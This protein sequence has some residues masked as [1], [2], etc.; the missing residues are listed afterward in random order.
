LVGV[1]IRHGDYKQWA[2]GKYFYS[3][4]DYEGLMRRA[5][6]LLPGRRVGFLVCS[7]DTV[8]ITAFGDLHVYSGSGHIVEDM[9]AFSL[10]DYVM[11]PPSTYTMW[12][13]FYGNVPLYWVY[14]ISKSFSL[15]NFL[16]LE[17]ALA[18]M[19]PA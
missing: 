5:V 2:G 16:E 4:S 7:N 18:L 6:A 9:Y 19:P 8:D 17:A 3:A 12:A 10:C 13:S 15:D 1:H 11:G 14:S